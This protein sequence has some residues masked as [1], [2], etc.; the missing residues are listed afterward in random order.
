MRQVASRFAETERLIQTTT[1]R[2]ADPLIVLL[3]PNGRDESEMWP[4]IGRDGSSGIP[5]P[6]TTPADDA[7]GQR[8]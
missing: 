8:Q 6:L 4:R 7:A 2:E 5:E 1:D 3:P